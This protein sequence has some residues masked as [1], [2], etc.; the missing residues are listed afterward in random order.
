MDQT[1]KAIIS[2]SIIRFSDG[3]TI[4][5]PNQEEREKMVKW[6]HNIESDFGVNI[7][8][9]AVP[10]IQSSACIDA[11]Y[12]ENLHDNS[13]LNTSHKQ[14]FKRSLCGCSMSTDIGGF[15][16]RKCFTGCIYCYGNASK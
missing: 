8:A 7:Y 2:K 1:P 16:P 14:P 12:L 11:E 5:S 13:G 15:P 6:I 9:C 4:L 10:G 3:L